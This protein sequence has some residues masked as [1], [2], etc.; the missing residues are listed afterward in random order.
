M[1]IVSKFNESRAETAENEFTKALKNVAEIHKNFSEFSKENAQKGYSLWIN[2]KKL[3][4]NEEIVD[5]VIN[6][7]NELVGKTDVEVARE[8]YINTANDILD[9]T[10]GS[11]IVIQQPQ[12]QQKPEDGT[13]TEKF[14]SMKIGTTQS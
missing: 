8:Q 10:K 7:M 6:K 1:K 9:I 5:A 11:K 2:E 14:K 12:Q 13:L 4:T 3:S